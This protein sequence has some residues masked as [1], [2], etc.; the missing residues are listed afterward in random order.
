MTIKQN[1]CLLAYMDCLPPDAIDGVWGPQS[2]Q[3]TAQMQRKLGI[4]D[5]GV[6]GA[7]TDTA[8]REYIYSGED[9]EIPEPTATY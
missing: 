1:Q 7:Q 3:A 9:L 2:A 5:D 4:P 8:V 6:W